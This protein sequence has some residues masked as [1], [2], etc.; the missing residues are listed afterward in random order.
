MKAHFMH[1]ALRK[2]VCNHYFY[3][4]IVYDENFEY[5]Y[6]EASI[7]M[8]KDL[9][10]MILRLP[11]VL[12]QGS[13]HVDIGFSYPLREGLSGFYRSKFTSAPEKSLI[14]KTSMHTTYPLR[15]L[16]SYIGIFL[17]SSFCIREDCCALPPL[18]LHRNSLSQ[19]RV[20]QY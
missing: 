13:A 19:S 4:V 10:Q 18:S 3:K 5:C 17:C 14:A 20:A 9:E 2:R 8:K 16:C 1:I 11:R 15:H 7:V 6:A 12:Q